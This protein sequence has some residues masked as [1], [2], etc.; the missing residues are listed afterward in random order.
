MAKPKFTPEQLKVAIL[1][2]AKQP[3]HF[4]HMALRLRDLH[5][6]DQGAFNAVI[7]DDSLGRRRAYELLR[8]ANTFAGCGIDEERL[9][10][11]GWTK[12][13]VVAQ[14]IADLEAAGEMPMPLLGYVDLAERATAHA[15]AAQLKT[16]TDPPGT[17]VVLLRL[18]PAD[19]ETY[20]SSMLARGAIP[21]G[22]GLRG[23]EAAL[24]QLISE[25]D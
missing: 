22:K 2:S 6:Q 5:A 17:R 11:I 12:L 19:Y 1:F 14:H 8:I 15:L 24:M 23:Q 18:T 16:L 3:R 20:R 25:T 9:E 21:R 13:A 10:A 7:Q 4:I